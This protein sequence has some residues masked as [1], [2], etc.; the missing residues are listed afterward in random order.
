M[1]D[2]MHFI[3]FTP[4]FDSTRHHSQ[5]IH[6]AIRTTFVYF[7]TDQ[8]VTIT[9]FSTSPRVENIIPHNQLHPTFNID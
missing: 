5:I 8:T 7:G 2:L 4:F 3:Y 1:P 9:R 6:F